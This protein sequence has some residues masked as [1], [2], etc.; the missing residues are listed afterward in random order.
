MVFLWE[1]DGCFNFLL[2][3][4]V[5]AKKVVRLSLVLKISPGN[6]L[7]YFNQSHMAN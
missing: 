5:E 1:I 4:T 6:P 7:K 3:D 2:E